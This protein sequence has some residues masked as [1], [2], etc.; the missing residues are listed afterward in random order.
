ML[1]SAL[2]IYWQA[3]VCKILQKP[4]PSTPAPS[5]EPLTAIFHS[6]I[7]S[8]TNMFFFSSHL[9]ISYGF[10][11]HYNSVV[12]VLPM[13]AENALREILILGTGFFQTHNQEAGR[14]L[15]P[16]MQFKIYETIHLQCEVRKSAEDWGYYSFHCMNVL[17]FESSGLSYYAVQGLA[18]TG[19]PH[20][21]RSRK[22]TR[23]KKVIVNWKNKVRE[24]E[25]LQVCF[26]TIVWLW[27]LFL[28]Q[29]AS[30][31]LKPVRCLDPTARLVQQTRWASH[32][33]LSPITRN[34]ILKRS[35]KDWLIFVCFKYGIQN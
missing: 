24:W 19:H 6:F 11:A 31:H 29:L 3:I 22:A 20:H 2:K 5:R 33:Q 17:T 12:S 8:R 9:A 7:Y 34:I 14:S 30:C 15:Q 23:N 32:S 1:L 4:T 16:E 27:P 35:L 28:T 18:Y 21:S 13:V 10:A 26:M 25:S